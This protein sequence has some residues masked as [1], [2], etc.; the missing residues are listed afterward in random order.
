MV[1]FKQTP[2]SLNVSFLNFH[3][4][5]MACAVTETPMS[6]GAKTTPKI[7][8][9]FAV[10][11]A[12]RQQCFMLGYHLIHGNRIKSA[13]ATIILVDKLRC[14]F[15]AVRGDKVGQWSAGAVPSRGGVITGHWVG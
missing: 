8:N 15:K 7:K 10:N 4:R 6:S 2:R 11:H 9:R 3:S 14:I 13:K 5:I 12:R 1:L